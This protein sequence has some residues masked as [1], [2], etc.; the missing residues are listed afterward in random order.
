MFHDDEK[1]ALLSSVSLSLCKEIVLAL[2]EN[3]FSIKAITQFSEHTMGSKSMHTVS[4]SPEQCI[5]DVNFFRISTF[6]CPHLRNDENPLSIILHSQ[7]KSEIDNA[8]EI[9]LF[10]KG[11]FFLSSAFY[12]YTC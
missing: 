1:T 7:C 6:E 9:N 5:I 11:K 4:P 10:P 2:S 8:E 3:R 12:K